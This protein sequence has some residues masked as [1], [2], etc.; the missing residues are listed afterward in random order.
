MLNTGLPRVTSADKQSAC[1]VGIN[2]SPCHMPSSIDAPTDI[3]VGLSHSPPATRKIEMTDMP[4]ARDALLQAFDDIGKVALSAGER[5]E[6]IVY[7]G[8]APT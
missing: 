1:P 6:L 2:D 3:A 7:G 5:L 4:L 8:S